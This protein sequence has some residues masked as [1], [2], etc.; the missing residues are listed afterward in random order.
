MFVSMSVWCCVR[1]TLCVLRLTASV[2]LSSG[3]VSPTSRDD[4]GGYDGVG[5]EDAVQSLRFNGVHLI[6]CPVF[7]CLSHGRET[8][9]L[10]THK[11]SEKTVKTPFQTNYLI[12]LRALLK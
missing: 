12:L 5:L 9:P 6:W 4:G 8:D 11:M 2:G 3:R 7:S 10:A 1:L